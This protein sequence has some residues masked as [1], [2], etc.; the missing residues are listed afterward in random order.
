MRTWSMWSEAEATEER[1][2]VS[3]IGEQWSPKMPPASDAATKGA[4]GRPSVDAAGTAIGSMIAKVP[5]EVP[6]EKAMKAEAMNTSGAA[7]TALIQGLTVA[8]THGPVPSSRQTAPIAVIGPT[9]SGALMGLRG[10]TA[11]TLR[12]V[13]VSGTPDLSGLV[14]PLLLRLVLEEPGAFA[15]GGELPAKPTLSASIPMAGAQPGLLQ[16]APPGATWYSAPGGRVRAGDE[17]ITGSDGGID[18]GAGIA[19]VALE[20]GHPVAIVDAAA[21][22]ALGV[23]FVLV[24]F[25]ARFFAQ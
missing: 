12:P 17:P 16:V 9:L 23:S 18:E 24:F 15:H 7:V 4:S 5:Q 21:G 25:Y 10:E 8:A 13:P 22:V 6:V 3:E 14:W 19:Q 11:A 2:V 1:T 20:A